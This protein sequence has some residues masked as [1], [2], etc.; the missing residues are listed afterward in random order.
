MLVDEKRLV[1]QDE[2]GSPPATSKTCVSRRRS[3]RFSLRVWN[4]CRRASA[5]WWCG[6]RS[7]ERCSTTGRSASSRPSCRTLPCT[8]I[9][10]RRSAASLIRPDRASFSGDDAYRFRHV[11]I[12]DAAYDSLSKTTRADLHERFAEWL[13]RAA[14]PRIREYEEIVGYHFEQACLCCRDIGAA[15][16]EARRLGA[17]ASERLE[18]AGRRAL[19]RGDLPAAIQLLGRAS[20]PANRRRRE[21]R[22]TAP[23]TRG[24]AHRNR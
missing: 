14:G 10:R 11:L 3:A 17:S 20:R 19:A 23:G 7:K 1:R 16:E 21:A 13:E 24:G 22:P 18:S 4:A 5:R 6:R 9:S 12:R 15:G 8:A 2:R